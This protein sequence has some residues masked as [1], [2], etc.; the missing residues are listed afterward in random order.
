[1]GRRG[2]CLGEHTLKGTGRGGEKPPGKEKERRAGPRGGSGDGDN[3]HK[4][5]AVG[6]VRR[7]GPGV[8]RGSYR[9]AKQTH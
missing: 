2:F 1:V 3:R 5:Y 8:D 4:Q 9:A 7:E 6:E